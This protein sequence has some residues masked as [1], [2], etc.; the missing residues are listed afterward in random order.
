[1][2]FARIGVTPFGSY[3]THSAHLQLVTFAPIRTN[4]ASSLVQGN[5]SFTKAGKWHQGHQRVANNQG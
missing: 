1:M 3:A 5:D 4:R 2:V